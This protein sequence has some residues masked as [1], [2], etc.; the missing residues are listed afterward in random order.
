MTR[1]IYSYVDVKIT[2]I[3]HTDFELLTSKVDYYNQ[4]DRLL[5]FDSVLSDGALRF[6]HIFYYDDEKEGCFRG[7]LA[8]A[9]IFEDEIKTTMI[10]ASEMTPEGLRSL[11]IAKRLV[12]ADNYCGE[13]R[14][15]WS[16]I[17]KS[18]ILQDIDNLIGFS[19]FKGFV[20]KLEQYCTNTK[21]LG[22]KANY[23]VVLINN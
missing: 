18:R 8:V 2:D 15:V 9:D 14:S 10:K 1:T 19:E 4:R 12:F 13:K 23:N 21:R 11:S 16:I 20:K 3:E 7:L 17:E 5:F 6:I 22:S